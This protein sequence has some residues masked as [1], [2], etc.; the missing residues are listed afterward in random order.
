MAQ[1]EARSPVAAGT[2]RGSTREPAPG[3]AI[4]VRQAGTLGQLAWAACDGARSPYNVLINIF[5]FA[6]YFTTV[7]IP[8][9][10]LLVGS[11]WS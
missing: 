10:V 11:A 4:A 9:P 3:T 5:V 7:V 8:D 6:A 1:S 2:L